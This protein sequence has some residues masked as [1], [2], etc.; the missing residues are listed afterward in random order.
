LVE[1][2]PKVKLSICSESDSDEG[3]TLGLGTKSKWSNKNVRSA[4]TLYMR[5]KHSRGASTKRNELLRTNIFSSTFGGEK[6]LTLLDLQ[7][8]ARLSRLAD[9]LD[10]TD[11]MVEVSAVRKAALA[12]Q[13]PT[14]RIYS[15][16]KDQF[17]DSDY[18]EAIHP[19]KK[20]KLFSASKPVIA[21]MKTSSTPNNGVGSKLSGKQEPIALFSTDSSSDSSSS[22]DSSSSGSSSSDSNSSSDNSDSSS[23]S[24]ASSDSDGSGDSGDSSDSDD[25]DK[26]TKKAPK[27]KKKRSYNGG[28]QKDLT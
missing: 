8:K 17:Y 24:D 5:E 3:R 9:G 15:E 4:Q 26:P 21:L 19:H 13:T 22:D 25:S 7:N 14:K 12:S 10:N 1:K 18:D 20:A 27:T 6:Q 11:K 28:R 2:N 23:S 16:S